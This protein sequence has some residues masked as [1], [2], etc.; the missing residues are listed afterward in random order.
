MSQGNQAKPPHVRPS[1]GDKRPD[2]DQ[3][4]D[5][6]EVRGLDQVRKN[7]NEGGKDD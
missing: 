2:K 4:P 1:R 5:M 3:R 7:H 6:D